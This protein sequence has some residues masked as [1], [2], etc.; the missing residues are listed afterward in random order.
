[1]EKNRG[2]IS[3]AVFVFDSG[4]GGLNLLYE[5]AVRVP[6]MRYYFIS[7]N[8]NVPYGNRTA[9]EIYRLTCN[10][11]DGI[12]KF[13]PAAL[14]VACNTVTAQC[15]GKLRSTYSFPVIGIQ[16]AVKPAA[17]YGGDS[18]VLATEATVHSDSFSALVSRYVGAG[19]K[20]VGCRGLAEYIERN[21]FNLPAELP[22]GLLPAI[23][24]DSVVLGCTHYTFVKKQIEQYYSCPVFDGIVGTADHFA[25][26]VG[27]CDHFS[28]FLGKTDHLDINRLKV[29]FLRGNTVKNTEIFK[30]LMAGTL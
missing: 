11:L 8:D 20:V 16:P 26:I 27:I 7:D 4:I 21:I 30:K 5:C 15:I 29:T 13:N 1:M 23:K 18:L 10:A 25:E 12:E 14:I 22:Q 2:C 19:F 3:D 9:Q 6:D 28:A 17:N 24:A